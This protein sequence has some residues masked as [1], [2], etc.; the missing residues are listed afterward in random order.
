MLELLES[1]EGLGIAVWIRESPSVFAYTLFLSLHAIGLAIVVG[2]SSMVAL[3]VVG[4]FRQIPLD[5]LLSLFP[6]MYVGFWVTAISGLLLLSA[7]ASGMLT[8]VMFYIK[9]AFIA[10]AVISLR[11]M[12]NELGAHQPASATPRTAWVM[13]GCWLGAIVAGRLTAYPYFVESWFGI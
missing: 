11:L 7:N 2:M 6:L 1:I 9:L 8:M 3:R 4:R 13:L 5:P 12:R 10:G